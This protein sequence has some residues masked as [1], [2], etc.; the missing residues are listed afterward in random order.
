MSGLLQ[1]KQ[2][3][4]IGAQRPL[5]SMCGSSP[6]PIVSLEDAVAQGRFRADLYYRLNVGAYR[7]AAAA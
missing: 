7:F 4:R 2:F 5:P 3:E 6:Q 1:E